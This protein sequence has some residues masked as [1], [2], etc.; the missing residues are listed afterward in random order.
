MHPKL[1][2]WKKAVELSIL[3]YEIT[4]SFPKSE[5]Y[6]LVNQMRRSVVSI[7]SNIAEGMVSY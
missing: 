1:N 6:G 3:G 7:P 5:L 4:E 2:V